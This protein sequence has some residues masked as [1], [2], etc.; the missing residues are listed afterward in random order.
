MHFG[1]G[2]KQEEICLQDLIE[3]DRLPDMPNSVRTGVL[4]MLA[5]FG[6]VPDHEV[7]RG[8]GL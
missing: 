4:A 2:V 7:N 6:H 3:G 5:F 1:A 8:S